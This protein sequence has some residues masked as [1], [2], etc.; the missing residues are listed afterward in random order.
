M[1]SKQIFG[2]VFGQILSNQQVQKPVV[3]IPDESQQNIIQELLSIL[4]A[5]SLEQVENI[6]GSKEL[7]VNPKELKGPI[8]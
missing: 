5:E 4:G 8:K 6:L 1:Q 2:H 7:S 3:Q